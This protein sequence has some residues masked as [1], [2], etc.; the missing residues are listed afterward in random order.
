MVCIFEFTSVRQLLPVHMLLSQVTV[1]EMQQRD[2]AMAS[3]LGR[4]AGCQCDAPFGGRVCVKCT[5]RGFVLLEGRAGSACLVPGHRCMP[6]VIFHA[7][8]AHDI[9]VV[10]QLL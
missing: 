3:P 1:P 2:G 6:D 9:C 4:A 7:S 10:R 8:G 5:N